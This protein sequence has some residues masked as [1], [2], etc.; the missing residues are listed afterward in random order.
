MDVWSVCDEDCRDYFAHEPGNCTHKTL[1]GTDIPM[2]R[3]FY[4]G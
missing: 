3:S 2:P 4:G 1:G